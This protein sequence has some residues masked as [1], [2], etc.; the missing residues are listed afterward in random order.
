MERIHEDI[1]QIYIFALKHKMKLSDIPL[2]WARF[3]R[4]V[5]A[6]GG[7]SYKLPGYVRLIMKYGVKNATTI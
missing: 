7:Q 1:A 2:N 3:A 5:K 4:A 6:T